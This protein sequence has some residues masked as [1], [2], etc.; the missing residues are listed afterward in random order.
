[1]M[2]DLLSVYSEESSRRNFVWDEQETEDSRIGGQK[3][4]HIARNLRPGGMWVN[5]RV[6]GG[7][8]CNV[9]VGKQGGERADSSEGFLLRGWG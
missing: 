2:P 5:A 7:R 6:R 4:K 1:L 8:D 3:G 9:R